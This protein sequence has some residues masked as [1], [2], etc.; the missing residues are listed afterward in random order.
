MMLQL[1]QTGIGLPNR[2]YYFNTDKHSV[3]IR[4]IIS[5]NIYL[6]FTS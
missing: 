1:Y 2:D 6:P 4:K 3:D 5:K